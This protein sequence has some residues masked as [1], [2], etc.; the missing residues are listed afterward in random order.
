MGLAP[1]G[2]PIYESKIKELVDIKDDGSFRLDQKYFNYA[3]S[4][5]TNNILTII[6]CNQ[7]ILKAND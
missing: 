3:T 6:W 7:G 2:K 1:Y 5:M 4:Y